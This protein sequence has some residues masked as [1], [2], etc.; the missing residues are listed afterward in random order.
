M[1]S[2]TFK[3][4]YIVLIQCMGVPPGV[5]SV[6]PFF[7]LVFLVAAILNALFLATALPALS[8]AFLDMP[9]SWTSLCNQSP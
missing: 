8:H 9:C 6:S 2:R 7:C 4:F 1:F 3:A 5:F